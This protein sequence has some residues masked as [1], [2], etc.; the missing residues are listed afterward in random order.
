MLA[1]TPRTG[2]EPA[3]ETFSRNEQRM[4]EVGSL[5]IHQTDPNLTNLCRLY[6]R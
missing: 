4:N 2:N 6:E 1:T 5:K 3:N